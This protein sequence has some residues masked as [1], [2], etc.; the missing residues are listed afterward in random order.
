MIFYTMWSVLYRIW[1]VPKYCAEGTSTLRVVQKLL[2]RIA[3]LMGIH[4]LMASSFQ[5]QLSN[6]EMAMK[7]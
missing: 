4:S 2:R 5:L 1:T 6:R 3:I 7:H